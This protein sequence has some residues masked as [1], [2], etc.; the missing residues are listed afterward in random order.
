MTFSKGAPGGEAVGE[1]YHARS[2]HE[3]RMQQQMP[4]IRDAI[5]AG[6]LHGATQA[7]TQLGIDPKLQNYYIRTT[8]HPSTRLTP[9]Q[10]QQFFS[11]ASPEE[12][13]RMQELLSAQ[14]GR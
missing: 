2:E 9:K 1:M 4:A 10:L 6:D 8:L 11:T 5:R 12:R 14:Q 7:M 13:Q 3:F